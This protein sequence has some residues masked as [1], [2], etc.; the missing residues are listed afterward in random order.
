LL[1]LFPNDRHTTIDIQ[2]LFFDFTLDTAT[3]FLV[4]QSVDALTTQTSEHN[5]AFAEAFEDA[6]EEMM[7]RFILGPL[8]CLRYSRRFDEACRISRAFVDK[9][10]TDA[11]NR[12]EAVI[13][14][15]HT[16]KEESRYIFLDEVA[17]ETQDPDQLRTAA[18][19]ILLAG[20]DT[21]GSL[22]SNAFF[23]FSQ[24]PEVWDKL[25]AEVACLEGQPPTYDQLRGFTYLRHALNEGSWPAC[26]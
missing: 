19:N 7:L 26:C 4:G 23:L 14:K 13:D 16:S 8:V 1:E 24:H 15:P 21:T 9:F 18:L 12:R 5:K 17:K 2:K 22:L 25:R 3:E 10:V 20:R 6:Q 11:L